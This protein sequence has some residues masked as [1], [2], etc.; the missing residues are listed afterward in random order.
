VKLCTIE[1]FLKPFHTAT[2]KLERH[3][4]TLENVL[5]TMDVIVKYFQDSLVSIF[6]LR[7]MKKTNVVQQ[8]KFRSN[9]DFASWI[10]KG[11]D[12]FNIYYSRTD[13]TP[14]YTAALILHLACRT[15]YIKTNWLAKWVK[16]NLKKVEKL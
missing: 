4:A 13:V 5:F 15:K 8:V 6:F 14:L 11:W 3:K 16:P 2:L 10:Q 9:K 7:K 1:E 12:V